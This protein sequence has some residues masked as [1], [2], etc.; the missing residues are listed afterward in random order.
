M[1]A[2][3]LLAQGRAEE[4]LGL[5][6]QTLRDN[7]SDAGARALYIQ[8]LFLRGEWEKADKQ[9]DA[10][11]AID[12]RKSVEVQIARQAVRCELA[13]QEV[14]SSGREPFIFGEPPAW[15]ARLVAAN[16]ALVAGRADQA[17][18]L[19]DAAFADAP[20]RPGRADT[21]PFAWLADADERLGPVLEA[22]I[23]GQYYWAPLERIAAI[24][25]AAPS[26]IQDVVWI[27][28]TLTTT[29]QGAV[30]ALLP[31]RYPGAPGPDDAHRLS[32]AT[33]FEAIGADAQGQGG[34]SVGHGQRLWLTDAAE[35]PILETR[36]I[37]FDGAGAE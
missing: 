26:H 5:V 18:E 12:P 2:E 25:I 11:G 30:A 31:V 20:A 6:Q 21:Q 24:E 36:R 19:R 22:F 32:R 17:A 4:A 29:N 16:K 8:I 13:R 7:P 9:L 28:A 14:F 37:E 23:Q 15:M 35:L 3:Q 34:V 27:T 33:S 1:A 10:L